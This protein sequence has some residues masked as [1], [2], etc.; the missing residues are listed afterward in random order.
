MKAVQFADYGGPEVLHL[1]DVDEP[2]AGPGQVRIAVRAAGVNPVDWKIRTG[3]MREVRPIPLPAGTGVDAAGV[4][5]EVGDG[6]DGVAIGDDVFG[7]GSAT[8]AEH[9]VLSHWAAKPAGLSF[10]EAAGYPVPVET[11]I[12]IINQVGVQPGET[13]LVSGAAGGVG[14]AVVQIA[15]QR[16]ISVIGTAG[17]T[18]QD[19]LRSL[20]AAATTYGDGLVGRVRAIAPD[21]VDAALDIAGSGVIDELI[22]LTGEPSK[23]LSIADFSAPAKGAQVSSKA[24][25]PD[26][27]YA[28]AA[29]LF[30]SGDLRIPVAKSFPLRDAAAAQAASAAG[31]LTGRYVVTVP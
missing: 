20:G 25:D 4:V 6:V 2:H 3:L 1:V 31:H 12:R 24:T 15:R 22:E 8:Y 13:L 16:G 11:A 17:A 27:A 10:A 30:S 29:R 9:A 19:Y 14:S 21:G 23:V 5:D 28:E 18:N 7:Q 26:G